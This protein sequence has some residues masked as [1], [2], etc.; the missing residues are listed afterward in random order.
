MNEQQW[1]KSLDRQAPTP[2]VD[3]AAS[4]LRDIR[5]RQTSSQEPG[6]GWPAL[7]ATLAGGG[8]VVPPVAVPMVTCAMLEG[9]E[10]ALN[11]CATTW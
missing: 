4:V 7:I 11:P 6:L 9:A 10:S 1:L 5:V 3:I 2:D 8:A